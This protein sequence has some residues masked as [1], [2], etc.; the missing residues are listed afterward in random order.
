MKNNI[1]DAHTHVFTD[2]ALKTYKKKAQGRVEKIVVLHDIVPGDPSL[3]ELLDFAAKHE[4]I[5]VVGSARMNNAGPI[6][7]QVAVL[8]SLLQ[9]RKIVGVKMYPG[10]EHFHA[11]NEFIVYPIADLCQEHN[12]PL[13]FH[14]GDVWDPEGT[15]LLE[16]S[17]DVS[18]CVDRLAME[19]PELKIVIAHFNFPKFM[20]CANV[21][22]KRDNVY[23]D[24]SGTIDEH[25]EVEMVRLIDQYTEDLKKAFAYFPDIKTKVMFG[26][27]YCEEGI[28]LNQ[29]QPYVE[30]VENVFT[31]EEQELVFRETA[32]KVFQLS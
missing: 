19:F 22:S 9:K 24:I 11:D 23:A 10:Y 25:N 3:L 31:K 26:T 20:E 13:M 8:D 18:L 14:A 28:S 27:D 1:I 12:V 29:F 6:D 2:E 15:A 16:Y 7:K 5:A 4:E 21:M 17:Y 30:L 32:R